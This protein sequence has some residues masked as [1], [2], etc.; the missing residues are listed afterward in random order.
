MYQRKRR[1]IRREVEQLVA[2]VITEPTIIPTDLAATV[3]QINNSPQV[4]S[5][6]DDSFSN[7]NLNESY[8]SD[9]D[10]TV[11]QVSVESFNEFGLEIDNT[12][13]TDQLAYVY[14]YQWYRWT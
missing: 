5:D 1:R 12:K 14:V 10:S 6:R 11:D 9:L 4:D 2:Q 8:L 7:L 3:H 13:L